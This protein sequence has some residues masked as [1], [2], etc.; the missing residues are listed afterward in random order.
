MTNANVEES[1]T[2]LRKNAFVSVRGGGRDWSSNSIVDIEPR[3]TNSRDATNSLGMLGLQFGSMNH[4]QRLDRAHRPQSE[5][6]TPRT[7][8]RSYRS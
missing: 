3:V 4:A 6:S 2:K 5:S 8:R 1:T 7:I